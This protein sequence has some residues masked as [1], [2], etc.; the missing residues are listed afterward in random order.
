M[1]REPHGPH[2]S[3]HEPF[4]DAAR[5]LGD[6]SR[7]MTTRR[8]Q[9]AYGGGFI[10]IRGSGSNGTNFRALSR[11]VEL[12]GVPERSQLATCTAGLVTTSK[13]GGAHSRSYRFRTPHHRALTWSTCRLR[14]CSQRPL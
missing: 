14:E 3:S 2:N 4:T 10:R 11:L 9:Y 13:K 12:A 7:E 5:L 1:G 6:V 8:R